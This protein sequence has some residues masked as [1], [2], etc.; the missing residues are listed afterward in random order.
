MW[1]KNDD[2]YMMITKKQNKP[3]RS[4]FIF[5]CNNT[6]Y[7]HTT[8]KNCL[9]LKFS[10]SNFSWSLNAEINSSI[11]TL[12]LQKIFWNRLRI[13][14]STTLKK[15]THNYNYFSVYYT[16]SI[17]LSLYY[18]ILSFCNKNYSMFYHIRKKK[19]NENQIESISSKKNYARAKN[20]TV[21]LLLST[22]TTYIEN[23]PL[24]IA[25]NNDHCVYC[26]DVN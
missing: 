12:A 2:D 14:L 9:I 18:T 10:L 5:H 4:S 15:M 24:K 6:I 16:L 23:V 7:K 17:I 8:N 26:H 19:K 22:T 13:Y 20:V 11:K 1:M 3:S 21:L 25:K